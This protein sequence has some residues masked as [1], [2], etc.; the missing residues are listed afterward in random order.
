MFNPV[1]RPY[2]SVNKDKYLLTRLSAGRV[3][4]R[5]VHIMQCL[6]YES[7]WSVF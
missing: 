6:L 5:G 1:L 4:C 2:Y 3:T 7:T